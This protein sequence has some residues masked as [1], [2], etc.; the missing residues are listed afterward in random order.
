MEPAAAA[1]DRAN[2][3]KAAAPP[4][5]VKPTREIMLRMAAARDVS[6]VYDVLVHYL[7][8]L[9]DHY[10]P[11]DEPAAM[12]RLLAAINL[13]GVVLAESDGLIVG[14]ACVE[15]AR[16][17]WN[18]KVGSLVCRLLYVLPEYR[19]GGTAKALIRAIQGISAKNR[20]PIYFD[21]ASRFHPDLLD[22]FMTGQ[23]F[24]YLGGIFYFSAEG[25][26]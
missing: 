18:P 19:K 17:E 2:A 11:P 5:V 4:P 12:T 23:G 21:I 24:T 26:E 3:R 16:C 10:P 14:A 25:P 22:R 9:S 7:G 13:G 8:E 20:L 1:S 15:P 6:A